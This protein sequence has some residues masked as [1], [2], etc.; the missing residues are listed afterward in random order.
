MEMGVPRKSI[1]EPTIN[2]KITHQRIL[3]NANT[4]LTTRKLFKKAKKTEYRQIFYVSMKHLIR[5]NEDFFELD[6][7]IFH[8]ANFFQNFF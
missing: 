7:S 2:H 1:L 8:F 4:R 6:C 3:L 5:L